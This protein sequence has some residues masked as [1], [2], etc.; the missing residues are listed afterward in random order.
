MKHRSFLEA[1]A[2]FHLIRELMHLLFTNFRFFLF[3]HGLEIDINFNP[4][5][6]I[7]SL[8]LTLQLSQLFHLFPSIFTV[9]LYL[10]DIACC[11]ELFGAYC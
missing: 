8:P 3:N 2:D 7:I 11:S 10:V 4:L 6:L 9:E 5:K 1:N